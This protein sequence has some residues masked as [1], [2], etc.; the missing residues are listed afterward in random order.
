M[1]ELIVP[2]EWV[3]INIS[4]VAD[5]DLGKTPKKKDYKNDGSYKVI[6][7]RDVSY[8]GIDWSKNKDGFVPESSIRDLRKLDAGDVLITASAHSSE[9]IGRKICFVNKVPKNYK[10]VFYCGELLGIR[11]YEDILDP[12][13]VFLYFLSHGGYKEIQSHVKGVHLTSGQAR[14]MTVPY[15]S[16]EEQSQIIAI[17]EQLFSDLDN[18]ID[19]LKKAKDQLK[20]YRQSVLKYAF[21]GK[22]IDN[23]EYSIKR[24]GDFD[25]KGG[26]TPS[27]KNKKYWNGD[28]NWITSASIDERSKIHFNKKITN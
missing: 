1:T 25:R 19:N 24:L 7:F 4:E 21:E 15:A 12:K 23:Y 2:K 22:F 5:V 27:T 10:N 17:V 20:V 18:A 13:F 3:K 28:I 14:N 8:D 9:H 26:G 16:Y 11:A 6:K